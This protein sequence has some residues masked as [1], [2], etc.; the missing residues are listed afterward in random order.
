MANQNLKTTEQQNTPFS[1]YNNSSKQNII[2]T[3]VIIKHQAQQLE[4]WCQGYS[5]LYNNRA[6]NY[7]CFCLKQKSKAVAARRDNW[8]NIQENQTSNDDGAE[9]DVAEVVGMEMK[10][11][12]TK[13]NRNLDLIKANFN[14]N[15]K[16]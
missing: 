8:V 14:L 12:E 10:G 13:S 7:T 5:K 15:S 9:V 6:T 3:H 16:I 2:K 11:A 4:K 1:V